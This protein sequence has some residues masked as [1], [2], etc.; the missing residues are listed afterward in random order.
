[1]VEAL[2]KQLGR[3]SEIEQ[4]LYGVL[5][6]APARSRV[7]A[8]PSPSETDPGR[9]EPGRGEHISDAQIDVF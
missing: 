8:R 6:V 9:A 7:Y 4:V 3:P 2:I 5:E 1:M